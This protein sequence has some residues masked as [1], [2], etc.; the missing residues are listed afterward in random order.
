MGKNKVLNFLEFRTFALTVKAMRYTMRN[1]KRK[2]KNP[3]YNL[4]RYFTIIENL[5][6]RN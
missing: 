1:E 2:V 3:Y 6:K 4:A 5:L